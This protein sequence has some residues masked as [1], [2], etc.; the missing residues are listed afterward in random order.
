M[1]SKTTYIFC[2][3]LFLFSGTSQI[4]AQI[5]RT[6]WF[7]I[8]K[9][10]NQ[11]STIT[12]TNNVSFKFTAF[13]VDAKVKVSMPA[14]PN[15]VTKI[16]TVKANMSFVDTLAT[17]YAEF[18]SIYANP[19]R[20]G[21]A[22]ATGLTN[23]G[24]LIESD[25]DISVYYDY[26]N[27][28]NRQL[29]SL[30]GKN[31]LGTDFYTPF[32]TIWKNN[33]VFAVSMVDIVATEDNTT[34]WVTPSVVFLGKT[35][36]P[37]TITLNKGQTYSLVASG[38]SPAN[39]PAGTHI[40]SD[41]PIAITVN[42]D[43]V[44]LGGGSGGCK[45]IIGD[46]IVPTNVI[47]MN[48]LVMVSNTGETTSPV[49]NLDNASTQVTL[50]GDQIFVLA[51]AN[52]TVVTYRDTSGTIIRRDTINAGQTDYLS[53][54]I[55]NTYQNAIHVNTTKPSYVF[56]AT[57][58]GCEM[59]GALLP[60]ITGCTGSNSVSF[61]RSST[62][63]DLT[64][65]LMIPYDTTKSFTAADQSYNF[66]RVYYADGS[67]NPIPPSWF[68]PIRSAGW[69]TL[70]LDKRINISLG[71]IPSNV[72][73]KVV[74]TKDFFHLGFTNGQNFSTNKYGYFSSYNTVTPGVT[75]ATVNQPAMIS[76]FGDTVILKASGGLEYLWRYGNPK[77]G[78]PTYLSDPHSATPRVY[79]PPGDHTFY[80]IIRNAKCFGN[81]TLPVY[82]T[83]YPE[84]KAG[85]KLDP[86]SVCAPAI[87]TLTNS[88]TN[89][90]QFEWSRRQDNGKD[91]PFTP[92]VPMS[93]TM[94]FVQPNSGSFSNKSNL[95]IVYS[96]LL[97][98][99]HN[100]VC[101]DSS[102][103]SV[104]IYP[105]L[106]AQFF[107][108]D[109]VGCNPLPVNFRNIS[110]GN[111][112][113][114]S[115]KWEFGD[116]GS[117]ILKA[118]A[119][120]YTNMFLVK[121]TSF[122]IQMVAT[123]PYFCRDT[124]KTTV[125]VHP[126]IKASFT[127]DTVQGCS[128]LTIRIVNNSENKG[129]ISQYNWDFGDGTSRVANQDTLL[130]TYPSNFS[131]TPVSYKF[132]LTVK[133]KNGNGCPDTVSRKIT[134]LPQS[135]ITFITNP[136]SSV[137][138]DST[139]VTFNTTSSAAIT[140]YIWD[141]GDGNTTNTKSPVHLFRNHTNGDIT[142]KVNVTGVSSTYCNAHATTN[143][144]VNPYLD[145]QFTTDV[146]KVCAPYTV[147]IT[148]DTHGGVK[149]TYWD[150]GD[151]SPIDSVSVGPKIT[152]LFR[153]ITNDSIVRSIILTIK[154][155]GTCKPSLTRKIVIYPE[156]HSSFTPSA[157]IGCNPLSVDFT[158]TS[159]FVNNATPVA[160]YFQWQFND[161]SSSSD[162]NVTHLFT[163]LDT[164]NRIFKVKLRVT[165]KF[166]CKADTMIPVTVYPFLNPDFTVAVAN[167]S[168]APFEATITNK[169]TGGI[170][171]YTWDFGDLTLVDKSSGLTLK[172]TYHNK[173]PIKFVRSLSL[174]IRNSGGCTDTL[175]R[176][177]IT[178]PEIKANFAPA[179]YFGCNP[180]TTKFTN[181]S[182]DINFVAKSFIWDF[183]DS[184]SS[185][186]EKPTHT[187]NNLD[188]LDRTLK[189][190]LTAISEYLCSDDTTIQ[191]NVLPYLNAKFSM[192][193]TIG[194]SPLRLGIKNASE[195]KIENYNW[196]YQD[197]T[198]NDNH[199]SVNYAHT[200]INSVTNN[201]AH[202]VLYR[203]IQ[204]VVSNSG[205]F[206]KD[207]TAMTTTIYPE[208]KADYTTNIKEGCNPLSI[209]YTNKSGPSGVPV[210][211]RWDMSD[212]SSE[213]VL[214]PPAHIFSNHK[215]TEQY[216]VT[217]LI[218]TSQYQCADT[219][220]DSVK[221]YPYVHAD[222]TVENALGCPKLTSK[223][224]NNKLQS[225]ANGFNW[226]FGNGTYSASSNTSFSHD[227][228]N[229]TSGIIT[230]QAKLIVD[231][232]GMCND[233]ATNSITVYPAVI[234][235]FT[236]DSLKGC[237][238]LVVKYT[239]KSSN[240]NNYTWSFGDNS[241]SAINSPA[242]TYYNFSNIDS[243][244][245][246]LL[247]AKSMY[248]CKDSISKK[249]IV[250]PKPKAIFSIENSMACPPFNLPI[251][252]LSQAADTFKWAFGDG[253]L[254]S[255]TT[256]GTIN[257]IYDNI[258]RNTIDYQLFLDVSTKYGCKDE[259]SQTINI[260]PH[261]IA[262]FKPDTAGCS[263]ILVPFANKTQG[264]NS[265]YWEFGDGFTS[266]VDAPSH[267][268]Y[269]MGIN[270]TTYKVYLYSYS[271]YGCEDST[272]RRVTVYPQPAV[273]FQALPFPLTFPDNRVFIT[274][275]TN[276]G[277][278]TYAWNFG[279]GQKDTNRDPS[280][281][282]YMHWGSYTMTLTATNQKCTNTNTQPVQIFAPQP[283]AEFDMSEPGCVPLTTKFMAESS[284]WF[285]TLKW[286]FDD[287]TTSTEQNPS[288][289]YE[290]AGK[291]FVRLTLYGDEGKEDSKVKELNVWPKPTVAF[292]VDPNLVMLPDATVKFFNAS[293]GGSK[294]S[295]NFG[296]NSAPSSDI[297]PSHNY[298]ELGVYDISLYVETD[299][300]CNVTKD[301]LK[302]IRVIGGGEI[303]FPNVFTPNIN[304]PGD[305]RYNPKS[306]QSRQVFHPHNLYVTDFH[307]EI[308]DRWGK[309]LFETNDVN[310]GWD[311]YYKGQ[312]CKSDVYIWY[313][314]G[315]FTNGKTF[316]KAGDVTLLR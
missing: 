235:N 213:G 110:N 10:T 216:F 178:Y 253:G 186:L 92:S 24:I 129:A 240:A 260:Y 70:K 198:P 140:S 113:D 192:D 161:S 53:P 231:Y 190:K 62:V 20:V 131:N 179:K 196:S 169:S 2:L 69:A 299:H 73:I 284:K 171:E 214:T 95:P 282:E 93:S 242:H 264:A 12:T 244:Y 135:T 125:T 18:D 99:S 117:S 39:H 120:T 102:R 13:N 254:L 294:Y 74:N 66:F 194:C 6:F 246:I 36:A 17:S 230:Y 275:T 218:A 89:A 315:K 269:N 164:S 81:D 156:I 133:H 139:T 215:L 279:D 180:F 147:T 3:L 23:R 177:V 130:H 142:Y 152:H 61:Y 166:G 115:F 107:P 303:S 262:D 104:V 48:Y 78:P 47:G 44:D 7:A 226:D 187:F 105:E 250:H 121:D 298:K 289:V 84:V 256:L 165:S 25:N 77:T 137:I 304:G 202:N 257:H 145:P 146:A 56:H 209:K 207:T 37:F 50:R 212:G 237:H 76:C 54:N 38:Q 229:K 157:V 259:M 172:H 119:H 223:F 175:K 75:I 307:M 206:C 82:V 201:P 210:T 268:Y 176:S 97:K 308:F 300:G 316:D 167:N 278:W 108:I 123:S 243:T 290:E 224:I 220:K 296:D 32:Q 236:Q 5:D 59:G 310:I 247:L 29:F 4:Y 204:L 173:L 1:R 208:V 136:N 19:A 41:K 184:T 71:L 288:H 311:G 227:F 143:I 222:F 211:Y 34:V 80:V 217:Q 271:D 40:T 195:G 258:S 21:N 111:I 191:V 287:G 255:S 306:E 72:A 134:V 28:N 101:K 312:L 174:V 35:M 118:P 293:K 249:V 14:N 49:L 266:K 138:C 285:N 46:Q 182:T 241:I 305:G 302:V 286:E 86:V 151:G 141:F 116:G 313:S 109:T 283:I 106:S 295:W 63:S 238:P 199:A 183:G 228:L 221:V 159:T 26:D 65:M 205:G 292:T 189:I 27:I 309:K 33:M 128:P 170:S 233:T 154:N 270:D 193:T 91:I 15:F 90:T 42:D 64:M 100:F 150:F 245:N 248:Q 85:F 188:T 232:N 127:V 96:Y 60:P 83:V 181:T 22:A 57:G 162:K 31:A 219:I 297:E 132:L 94:T 8:P 261:V 265:S 126:Y 301:S 153:N 158:N 276:P 163:N 280:S 273:S 30:K 225:G 9:E 148:N 98:A 168:C 281:H 114:S 291:Y 203:K 160:K 267:K 185:T 277:L 16:F 155:N 68:E 79:C 272:T 274:N 124:A 112:T 51:T 88:S 43:S 251:Y 144:T 67:S 58:I 103:I 263:P 252:N 45:D 239:N 11:H 87:V 122:K 197:G 149:N 55:K 200:F 314:K 52:N 234:A